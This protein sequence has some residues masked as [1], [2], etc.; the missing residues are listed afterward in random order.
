[1]N[2]RI[3]MWMILI[4]IIIS[5]H[6]IM[7]QIQPEARSFP[8][9][10]AENV[11]E[12]PDVVIGNDSTFL[13]VWNDRRHA[14]PPP[15][16][17]YFDI[18]GALITRDSAAVIQ[19]FLISTQY[20]SVGS[21]YGPCAVHNQAEDEYLV[22]WTDQTYIYGQLIN[23]DASLIGDNVI[24]GFCT[25]SSIAGVYNSVDNT[26]CLT[27]KTANGLTGIILDKECS[28]LIAPFTIND[29]GGNQQIAYNPDRNE[30]MV[31]YTCCPASYLEVRAR[32]VS[33]KGKLLG[34]EIDIAT[35]NS[36]S[37]NATIAYNLLRDEYL[38]TW[39]DER[40]YGQYLSE[41]WARRYDALGNP[42]DDDYA[43]ISGEYQLLHPP[44]LKYNSKSHR[45]LLV[46]S[47]QY[48]FNDPWKFEILG[49]HLSTDGQLYGSLMNF[50]KNLAVHQDMPRISYCAENNYYLMVW[51]QGSGLMSDDLD[52]YGRFVWGGPYIQPPIACNSQNKDNDPLKS[53][54]IHAMLSQNRPNPV[55]KATMI[56]YCVP[57]AG[58][59]VLSV[60]TVDGRKVQQLI[61]GSMQPGQYSVIWDGRDESGNQVPDGV[62]FYQLKI[63]SYTE[64]KKMLVIR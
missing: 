25:G 42:I 12:V 31:V 35:V 53:S 41:I 49:H 48:Y 52:V 61:N 47:R 15:P 9:C 58:H 18:Y 13:V 22:C 51:H 62:Y 6:A 36:F 19:E 1:M 11:Q 57:R 29:L 46:W 60:C 28:V 5:S 7:A 45:Y 54:D 16:P 14:S 63:G 50:R 4:A 39:Y 8:V 33:R 17:I 37:D 30:Y 21:F 64:T 26:Y 59:I 3:K 23:S 38:I 55:N 32:R 56:D 20:Q 27:Y 2:K 44:S 24:I 10:E 43:L 34:N 40:N